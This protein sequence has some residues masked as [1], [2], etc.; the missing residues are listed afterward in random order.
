MDDC[1]F[2]DLLH[3]SKVGENCADADVAHRRMN[4]ANMN[5]MTLLICC[6]FNS[7]DTYPW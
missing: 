7:A 1:V 2:A 4:P 5:L 6:L 3:L